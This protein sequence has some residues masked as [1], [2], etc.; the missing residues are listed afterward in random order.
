MK[1]LDLFYKDYV[2]VDE[3]GRGC[4]GG[5]LF[6]CGCKLKEGFTVEDI[7]FADDS[8]SMNKTKREALYIEIIKYVDY[9]LTSFN[10]QEIDELGLSLCLATS[11]NNVKEG[12]PKDKILYDGNCSYK[13]QGIE[14][15][16]K[17]D[18]KVSIVSCASII[19]KH[20]KDAEMEEL[21]SLYPEYS[22]NTNNGYI[23]KKNTD[24]IIKH[25]YTPAHRKSYN[26]KALDGLEIKDYTK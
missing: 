5:S 26:L 4:V 19:A 7:A 8:K 11:L 6:F 25:G 21:H 10:A 12:F 15:L 24:A 17:A 9:N 16:V 2:G 13:V 3:S 23:N 1:E 22:F 20:F 14:T 18:A